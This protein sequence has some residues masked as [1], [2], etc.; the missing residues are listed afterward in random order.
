VVLPKELNYI[1]TTAGYYSAEN[2]TVVVSVGNLF[3]SQEGSFVVS[4][5]VLESATIG[6]VLVGTAHGIY[7]IE[8]DGI[9]EEV[10]SYAKN[11]AVQAGTALAG[12]ALF[13]AGFWPTTLIGWLLLLLVI[14][15][16][17]LALRYVLRRV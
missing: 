8:R 10:F 4:V 3:P 9:Q 16:I 2:N 5:R 7:T 6:K 13:G 12:T 11:E 17:L 14:F 15:L 1:S